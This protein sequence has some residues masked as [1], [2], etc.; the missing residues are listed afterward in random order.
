MEV[1]RYEIYAPGG[2]WVRETLGDLYRYPAQDEVAFVAGIARQYVRSAQ[3]FTATG[4]ANSRFPR[5]SRA[6]RTIRLNGQYS[7][8]LCACIDYSPGT[9]DDRILN[10]PMPITAMFPF[11]SRT[12]F[13]GSIDA[14]FPS[15]TS[16][17]AYLFKGDSYALKN[18]E[19]KTC[20]AT[21]Q[22]S[23]GFHGLRNTIFQSG[24]E[25]AFASHRR[26]EAYIFKGDQ[27][28]LINFAP[29]S[30]NDYIIG[31][32]KPIVPNWPSLRG[33][34]PRTNRGLD[35]HA[36]RNQAQ[37]PADRGHDEL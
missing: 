10:G 3:L 7:G 18:Y 29:G 13:A 24:L 8:N 28:A 30:N 21:R 2:I 5:W 1:Y 9:T 34:L 4:Q 27:Y 37:A 23:Q 15:T 35:D 16:N 20:I 22:I 33:I 6:D 14:A 31:G 19:S 11:F 36:H 32:V 17:E 25:A 26:N 12:V